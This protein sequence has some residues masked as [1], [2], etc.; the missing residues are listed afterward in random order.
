MILLLSLPKSWDGLQTALMARGDDLT[1]SF[2]QQALLS[3]ELKRQHRG[4]GDC[5]DDLAFHGTFRGECFNCG[6]K[7][8]K[9]FECRKPKQE[10]SYGNGRSSFSTSRGKGKGRN[11]V[12]GGLAG[13]GRRQLSKTE[14]ARIVEDDDGGDSEPSQAGK[15][16]VVGLLAKG[17]EKSVWITDSGASR[18]MTFEKSW[19]STVLYSVQFKRLERLMVTQLKHLAMEIL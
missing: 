18:H 9:S 16:F 17:L 12:R 6:E 1:L 3:E 13:R 5:D 15:M 7:G 2:V 14:E 10:D 4:E 19:L 8:H 11:Q